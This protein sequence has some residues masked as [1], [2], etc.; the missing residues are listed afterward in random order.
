MRRI[1]TALSITTCLLIAG[2]AF[3]PLDAQTVSLNLGQLYA[4]GLIAVALGV[5]LDALTD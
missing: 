1:K 2:A 4:G 3:V 5:I